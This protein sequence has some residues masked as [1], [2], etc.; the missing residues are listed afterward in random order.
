MF[1]TTQTEAGMAYAENQT[2]THMNQSSCPR[3]A[4]NQNSLDLSQPEAEI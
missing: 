3:C 2:E 1:F 4:L